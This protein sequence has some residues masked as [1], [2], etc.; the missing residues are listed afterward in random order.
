MVDSVVTKQE[1]I[2]AQKDAQSLEDVINGPADTRVKPRIGPEMW[3][4]ATINSLVQQGQIK[5][6][7]LSEAI[8]I[9]LAAGAGS[10]GWTANLVADGNQTQKEINLFGGKKY[11]MPV[12]GYPVGAVVLLDNG[13][14]VKSTV[15][16]NVKNPNV[17]MTGWVNISAATFSANKSLFLTEA[18]PF[19]YFSTAIDSAPFISAYANSLN[20]GDTLLIPSGKWA[21]KS[22]CIISKA[23]NIRCD[24]ELVVSGNSAATLKLARE[25]VLTISGTALTQLP[26]RGDTKL[27]VSG[28]PFD[29]ATHFFT[30]ESTEVEIIRIGYAAPYY[31]NETLDFIDS[32]FNLRGQIDLDYTDA[33]KLTIKVYKKALPTK[34]QLNMSMIPNSGQTD[35][36]KILETKGVNNIVWDVFIDRSTSPKVAG[37]SFVYENCV[38]FTFMPSCKILGGQSDS[39]DSYAF[40]NGVSSYIIHFG[41]EY[42]DIGMTTKKERGYAGRHGKYV[43]F[44]SSAFNGIDDHMGHHYSIKDM[45]FLNR[46]IGISGGDIT[47]QNCRQ[48]NDA[49]YLYYM[50]QD[51]PYCVG[52]L[53]LIDCE[54]K[55]LC[56]LSSANNAA[57]N[58]KFKMFD[59]VSIRY[60]KGHIKGAN[61][62]NI[63]PFYAQN[64]NYITDKL[65]VIGA[66]VKRTGG[67]AR[68]ISTDA[69]PKFKEIFIVDF[70][71]T[72]TDELKQDISINLAATESIV[73]R[74]VRKWDGALYAPKIELDNS[75]YGYN[76]SSTNIVIATSRLVLKNSEVTDDAT[77]YASG[78]GQG[79]VFLYNS[80]FST[81]K[82][83]TVNAFKTNMQVSIGS[84][85]TVAQNIDFDLFNYIKTPV[86]RFL[87]TSFSLGTLAVGAA[88]A[89][90]T[91]AVNGA[92]VGNPIHA[93]F[94]VNANGL[95]INA[96]VSALNEVKYYVENPTAN[97]N[98]SQ[99]FANIGIKITVR[100]N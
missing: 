71:L 40:L 39:N 61:F 41:G 22:P 86:D 95:R 15:T 57:Y 38:H 97:P 72:E 67:V 6:S 88:S 42:T 81:S 56:N 12:G 94:D 63:G 93:S 87:S 51:T 18:R 8:Q 35:G 85:A 45:I 66:T 78:A 2:D 80:R 96:W 7:D 47:I 99:T 55:L 64:T 23:I 82:F 92:R 83:L 20:D 5:I 91:V 16:N 9:A 62:I 4:L 70:S 98:G 13:D 59:S 29:S 10:A 3:T 30:L 48:Y 31:K 73:L 58:S 68:F 90:Q 84:T 19:N 37:I 24:G 21:I 75:V 11:D 100:S 25:P 77:A 69:T 74:N 44:Q 60:P 49:D 1:L 76:P 26:K 89:V 36:A 14:I 27:Y 52:E 54:A 17:D 32:N 79:Q 50:R 43:Y 53:K 33:S 65:E 34:V 28:T 46:G